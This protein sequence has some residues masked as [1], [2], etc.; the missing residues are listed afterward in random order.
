MLNPVKASQDNYFTIKNYD[1]I[2]NGGKGLV[3]KGTISNTG[4]VKFFR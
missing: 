4:E 2:K 1:A 3:D